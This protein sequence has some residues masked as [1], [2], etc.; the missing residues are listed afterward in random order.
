MLMFGINQNK[1]HPESTDESISLKQ[2]DCLCSLRRPEV[3][4]KAKVSNCLWNALFC[5]G[6]AGSFVLDCGSL[7]EVL[8]SSGKFLCCAL[9]TT[10]PWAILE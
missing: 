6:P 7:H 8:F 4:H 3:R 2:E 9:D 10:L 5:R 1:K